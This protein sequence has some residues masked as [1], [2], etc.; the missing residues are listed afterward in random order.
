MQKLNFAHGA[1]T[2]SQTLPLA[3]TTPPSRRT[4]AL[5]GMAGQLQSVLTEL[6]AGEAYRYG[7]PP[8]LKRDVGFWG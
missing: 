1:A 2:R 8:Q 3:P 4:T 5:A 7:V 6:L